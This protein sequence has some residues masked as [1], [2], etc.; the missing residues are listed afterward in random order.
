MEILTPAMK[1]GDIEQNTKIYRAAQ[2][3][4]APENELFADAVKELAPKANLRQKKSKVFIA[5]CKA[6]GI[7]QNSGKFQIDFSALCNEFNAKKIDFKLIVSIHPAHFLTMSNPHGSNGKLT[8]G[9]KETMVSCHSLDNT[10]CYR[11][12]AIGYARDAVTMIAFTVKDFSDKES[13]NYRKTSRQLFMYEVGN[14]VL[15]QSRLYDSEVSG[16]SYGGV[17]GKADDIPKYKIYRELIEREISECEN[18]PNFWGKADDYNYG[19][20]QYNF[21]IDSNIGFGGYA[22]WEHFPHL[23]KITVL[24]AF[25]YT[26]QEFTVG[27]MGL[28]L[29]CGEETTDSSKLLCEGCRNKFAYCR[30]CGGYHLREEMTEVYTGRFVCNDC[31]KR[32]YTQCEECGSYYYNSGLTEIEGRLLCDDCVEK[33]A[34]EKGLVRCNECGEWIPAEKALET[35]DGDCICAGYTLCS[36]C[37]RYEQDSDYIHQVDGEWICQSCLENGDYE[38][39][40]DCG[41]WVKK[42][43]AYDVGSVYSHYVCEDC[44]CNNYSYCE[45]C[46]E[47]YHIDYIGLVYDKD[48]NEKYIC[49]DCRRYNGYEKCDKCGEYWA[50]DALENGLCPECSAE[51]ESENK[52]SA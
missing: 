24:K 2:Y 29:D 22:D 35:T 41:K 11:N 48:G 6:L 30:D 9:K 26:A 20:N 13:L 4:I 3:F 43:F 23:T 12:G 15:L 25:T 8:N 17:N 50:A 10:G 40:K 45:D 16:D 49:D 1:I 38:K 5:L 46:E 44:L 21:V 39:C 18:V 28:C 52:K 34:E 36:H 42:Q 14:G 27:Q 7:W 31:L 47:Y 37:G 51:K 19:K 33:I 32:L